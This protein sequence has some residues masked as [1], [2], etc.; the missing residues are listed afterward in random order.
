[1]N[2]AT[3]EQ[4]V[5][6][7]LP[8]T[9]PPAA[10]LATIQAPGGLNPMV[11]L[12]RLL[13][14][15]HID[16]DRAERLLAMMKDFRAW[17]KEDRE[18]LA[19]LAFNR[20]FAGFRGENVIVP[21]GKF[22][23]RGN[24]GSFWHAEFDA[25]CCLLSPALSKHGFSFRHDQRFS[26]REWHADG[27]N[28]A[29]PAGTVITIPWVYVT[30]FLAH[31]AGHVKQI[32]LEGPPSDNTAN[33]PVQNMQVTASV[34]KRQTLVS[35]TGTATGGEDDEAQLQRKQA[36]ESETATKK[37][38]ARDDLVQKGRDAA[39]NGMEALNAWWGSLTGGQRNDLAKD[40]AVMRGAARKADEGKGAKQ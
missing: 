24:A 3:A 27:T 11:M 23:N 5:L 16:M 2:T 28:P 12:D 14:Q 1:M 20:A 9:P 29:I 10:P 25:V 15:P 39:M 21:K 38:A 26:S 17:E 40:F 4:P 37:Q 36:V 30:C 18:R 22:V 8:T 7:L 33:T 32:E 19:E 6:E 34:L 13:Q 31:E 35:I